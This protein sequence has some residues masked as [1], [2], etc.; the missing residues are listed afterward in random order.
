LCKAALSTFPP[1]R[2]K[3]R[4][5]TLTKWVEERLNGRSDATLPRS[6]VHPEKFREVIAPLAGVWNRTGLQEVEIRDPIASRIVLFI[7]LIS[8]FWLLLILSIVI[9]A[10]FGVKILT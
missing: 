4:E 3:D 8:A 6:K 2:L 7:K 5:V 9:L 10:A 1:A